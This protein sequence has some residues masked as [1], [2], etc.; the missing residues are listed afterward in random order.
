MQK[1]IKIMDIDMDID[2]DTSIIYCY[3]DNEKSIKKH[4]LICQKVSSSKESNPCVYSAEP[5][6]VSLGDF[7]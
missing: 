6:P 5:S 3:Y 4:F 2:I 7:L 1:Q